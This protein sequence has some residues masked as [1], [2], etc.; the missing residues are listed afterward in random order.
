L[1]Y[2]IGPQE[3]AAHRFGSTLYHAEHGRGSA[4]Y[5][6]SASIDP[7]SH[8]HASV[9]SGIEGANGVSRHGGEFDDIKRG[10]WVSSA[11]GPRE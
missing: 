5:L 11:G 3:P 9:L 8:M 7:T 4:S 6:M 10:R 2:T 1:R